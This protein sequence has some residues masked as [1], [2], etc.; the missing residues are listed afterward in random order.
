MNNGDIVLHKTSGDKGV[1]VHV[2]MG[3]CGQ[4]GQKIRSGYIDVSWGPNNTEK[5]YK[6][7][8]KKEEEDK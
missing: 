3:H 8:L 2:Y 1:I 7:A 6:S 5:I 4:T